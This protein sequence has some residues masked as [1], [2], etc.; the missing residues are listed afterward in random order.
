M[1]DIFSDFSGLQLNRAK[2]S[3]IGSGLSPEELAGCSRI[4][5]TPIG[6]ATGGSATTYARLAPGY[7]EGGDTTRKLAARQ[8]SQGGRLALLK[9]VLAAIPYYFMAIFRMPVGVRRRLDQLMRG[10]FWLGSRLEESRGVALV[11]YETVCHLVDQCSL[12]VRQL[13]HTNT[14]LLSKWVCRLL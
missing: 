2:S 1:M 4:L 8:L 9:A 11:A 13:L 5:A 7:R 10:F 12:G 6:S 3:F 14:A